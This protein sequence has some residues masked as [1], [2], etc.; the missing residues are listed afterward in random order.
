MSRLDGRVK[1]LERLGRLAAGC[2]TCGGPW[3]YVVEPGEGPPSWFDTSSCCLDC[4]TGV[5]LIDREAWD[6]L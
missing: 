4:G 6:Q 3:C 2:A 1:V 5:K